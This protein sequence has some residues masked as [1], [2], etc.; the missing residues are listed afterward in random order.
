[1]N[2]KNLFAAGV[3]ALVAVGL[4]LSINAYSAGDG[5]IT[6]VERASVQLLMENGSCSGTV[7]KD[8]DLSDVEQVTI[9]TAKHCTT[10]VN[11]LI[12][13]PIQLFDVYGVP[14]NVK[15]FD[16]TVTKQSADSDV[17][18]IQAPL[19]EKT[20]EFVEMTNPINIYGGEVEF[21][22]TI[23]ATGFPLGF[24][25]VI[26]KGTAGYLEVLPNGW[27]KSNLF[28][29][30]TF[31]IAPGMSG[32]AMFVETFRGFEIV[33]V[34]TGMFNGT[35]YAIMSPL[36]EIKTFLKEPIGFYK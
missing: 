22:Q 9:L 4:V 25:E 24:G 33:G 27:S 12:Q 32:G 23:W 29:R 8:P 19:N 30:A 26:V 15:L 5:N 13:V 34:T 36:S 10:S 7:I 14:A 2:F 20:K 1:M 21:G 31:S 18:I 28:Q 11:E 16:F 6:N 35:D 17:A 3:G